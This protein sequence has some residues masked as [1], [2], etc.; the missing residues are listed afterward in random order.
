MGALDGKVA[1]V[2]GASRG[3]DGHRAEAPVDIVVNNAA[4][5]FLSSIAARR[6]E[7]PPQGARCRAGGPV[8]GM[9]KAALEGFT[10]SR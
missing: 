3:I 2:T 5:T 9:C 1:L 10:T 8:H 6:P 7:L 4:V